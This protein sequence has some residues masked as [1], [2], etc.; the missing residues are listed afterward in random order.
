MLAGEEAGKPH[1]VGALVGFDGEDKT[2]ACVSALGE[3]AP[4]DAE[5]LVLLAACAVEAWLGERESAAGGGE[6]FPAKIGVD[7][8]A[9]LGH[10]GDEH[11]AN[12]AAAQY[13][14]EAGGRH[15]AFAQPERFEAIA[16]PSR[17]RLRPGEDRG[18][19]W[20]ASPAVARGF[21]GDPRNDFGSREAAGAEASH[22]PGDFGVGP[23]AEA[24]GR[25]E[26]ALSSG[27]GHHTLPAQRARHGHE[28]APCGGGDVSEGDTGGDGCGW[29]GYHDGVRSWPAVLSTASGGNMSAG[30][31][32]ID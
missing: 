21:G 10:G 4:G 30:G 9:G 6:V 18:A 17:L 2:D 16:E 5:R 1:A 7:A 25:F 24:F 22:E 28:R 23:V 27:F 20:R 15:V 13:P 12:A 3:F 32:T 8:C 11:A 26:N 19:G 14:A 31:Q 29:R